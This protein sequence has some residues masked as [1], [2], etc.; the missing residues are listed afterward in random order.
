MGKI[1]L[2]SHEGIFIFLSVLVALRG[3]ARAPVSPPHPAVK[4]L[5]SGR[6]TSKG[7]PACA[8]L[9]WRRTRTRVAAA[10]TTASR[11]FRP[12]LSRRANTG[13]A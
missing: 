13:E 7:S 9:C 8:G 12:Q 10:E 11:P 3:P 4:D 6:D 2:K 5:G 1:L